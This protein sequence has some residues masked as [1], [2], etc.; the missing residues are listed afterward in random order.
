MARL[1]EMDEGRLPEDE[2]RKPF[3]LFYSKRWPCEYIPGNPEKASS[4]TLSYM[5][6]KT[7]DIGG[8]CKYPGTVTFYLFLT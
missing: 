1:V 5:Q 6:A 7:G 8:L 3:A 4:F 2:T